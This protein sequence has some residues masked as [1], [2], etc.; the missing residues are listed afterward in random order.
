MDQMLNRQCKNDKDATVIAEKRTRQQ[1]IHKAFRE[2]LSDESFVHTIYPSDFQFPPSRFVWGADG[3][4]DTAIAGLTFDEDEQKLQDELTAEQ[5]DGIE[6]H[7]VGVVAP[8]LR[9]GTQPMDIEVGHLVVCK[10]KAGAEL[11]GWPLPWFLAEVMETKVS[12]DEGL[13]MLKVCEYGTSATGKH[14]PT[15]GDAVDPARVRWQA[16]FRGTELVNGE[17]KERDEYRPTATS[18]HPTQTSK[19]YLPV[20]ALVEAETVIWWNGT[21]KMLRAQEKR[22]TGRTLRKSVV[23]EVSANHRVPWNMQSGPYLESSRPNSGAADHV[24]V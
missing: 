5:A 11:G 15:L 24:S 7:F 22:R 3:Y 20:C 8:A 6:N 13:D 18:K 2:H 12:N 10:A 9:G 17:F 1:S 4:T 21:D 14:I 19:H 23:V 16:I